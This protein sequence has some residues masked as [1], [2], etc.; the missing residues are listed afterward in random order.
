MALVEPVIISWKGAH[1]SVS[2]HRDRYAMREIANALLYQGRTGPGARPTSGSVRAAQFVS[3]RWPLGRT[4]AIVNEKGILETRT[5]MDHSGACRVSRLVSET[6]LVTCCFFRCLTACRTS[7]LQLRV[8]AR[9]SVLIGADRRA[10]DLGCRAPSE[11]TARRS[12]TCAVARWFGDEHSVGWEVR[13]RVDAVGEGLDA[14]CRSGTRVDK[15]TG[16]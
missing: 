6:A 3:P 15:P 1:P 2:G 14:G 12:P 16:V 8:A 9:R 11:S 7:E 5:Y 4:G 10:C 13:A